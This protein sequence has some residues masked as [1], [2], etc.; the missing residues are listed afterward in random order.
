MC[1]LH[2]CQML[3]RR[4]RQPCPQGPHSPSGRWTG[5]FPIPPLWDQSCSHG[6][7]ATQ[8]AGGRG[9]K[10]CSSAGKGWL[11]GGERKGFP[12]AVTP[13]RIPE[14]RKPPL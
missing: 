14:L 8:G 10:G 1:W 4:I 6:V 13:G 7:M 11:G 2:L 5:D 9:G 3:E 12:E